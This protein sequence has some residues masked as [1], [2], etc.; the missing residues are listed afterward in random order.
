MTANWYV[1]MASA[2]AL[3][4]GA[5]EL[6]AIKYADIPIRVYRMV[7]TTGKS[8]PGG[9][10]AGLFSELKVVILSWVN[11]AAKIPPISGMA[12]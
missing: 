8:Q 12:I 1:Y 6:P 10:R 7:H 3:S 5:A 4:I 2:F 11:R 9:D